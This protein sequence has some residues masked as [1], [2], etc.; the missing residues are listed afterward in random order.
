MSPGNFALALP[1]SPGRR[2]AQWCEIA[3]RCSPRSASPYFLHLIFSAARA[4]NARPVPHPGLYNTSKPQ[5]SQEIWE[6][7]VPRLWQS[8][9]GPKGLSKRPRYPRRAHSTS[10][11]NFSAYSELKEGPLNS[12]KRFVARH[13]TMRVL[14]FS[15]AHDKRQ[16]SLI[17][18]MKALEAQDWP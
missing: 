5:T 7:W 10:D 12:L 11:G 9:H 15:R 3:V 6:I 4:H 17:S 18:Q 1:V 8:G 2:T 13:V 16:E 14:T